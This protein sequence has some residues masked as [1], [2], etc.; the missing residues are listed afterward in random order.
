MRFTLRL[1][2]VLVCL[3]TLA[4]F[5]GSV[6]ADEGRWRH[7]YAL[8][9]NGDYPAAVVAYQA[10]LAD[11]PTGDEARLAG[12][13]LGQ[14]YLLWKDY[15]RAVEALQTFL[16]TYPADDLTPRAWF[17]L[18]LARRGAGD[19]AGALAAFGVYRAAGGVISDYANLRAASLAPTTPSQ[20]SVQPPRSTGDVA[21]YNAAR[22]LETSSSLE[23]AVDAYQRFIDA[24]PQSRLAAEAQFRLGLAHYRLDQLDDA[25]ATWHA[26][27]NSD[28]S[29]ASRSRAA[30]WLSRLEQAAGGA[31]QVAA[32]RAQAVALAPDSF[33]G[34]RAK[35]WAFDAGGGGLRGVDEKAEQAEFNAWLAG[36]AGGG[37]DESVLAD[38]RFQRA[39]ELLG[40]GLPAAAVRELRSLLNAVWNQ[41]R[42][43]AALALAAR[44]RQVHTI[45]SSAAE[46][47]GQLSPAQW[48][49]GTPRLNQRLA[50]PIAYADI[51]THEATAY[52]VDPLWL[53]ALIR[54]ES[55]FDPTATSLAGARGLTQVM[56]ATGRSIAQNLGLATWFG[57]DDLYR[58]VIGIPFG[59]W[60]W[61]N[62][63]GQSG[64]PLV[65]LAGYNG[66]PGNATRWWRNAEGD[67][68]LFV[69]LID[70]SETATFVKVIPE[71]YARYRAIYR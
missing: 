32:Y 26:Q 48:I 17:M 20:T 7:G 14:A 57:V 44:E 12:F 1:A 11:S 60:Y 68:D 43:L 61:A 8:Q 62:G 58:P 39:D 2:C 53:F 3:A 31:E 52:G 59:A 67:L 21:A 15:P 34:L 54:Q 50:Y 27:V 64:Q 9:Q 22:R 49:G 36:W 4:L 40:V 23:A 63:L 33:Y 28:A 25:R 29:T 41:P 13:H 42:A 37:P 35:G 5:Y 47:L 69:E 6:R 18:G 16:D 45:A 24:Y 55:R 46:R 19:P 30:Y 66:G 65:A 38:E 56:P 70:L 10:V 51:V 71:Q